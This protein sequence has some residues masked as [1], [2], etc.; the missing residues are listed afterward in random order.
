MFLTWAGISEFYGLLKIC[1]LSFHKYICSKDWWELWIVGRDHKKTKCPLQWGVTSLG[2]K[3]AIIEK[4][5]NP[6]FWL[7]KCGKNTGYRIISGAL[8]FFCQILTQE[9]CV[10]GCGVVCP[11]ANYR[12]L[13]AVFLTMQQKVVFAQMISSNSYSTP[14]FLTGLQ[15]PRIRPH[16]INVISFW[17]FY[18]ILI[19]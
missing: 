8:Y 15:M 12:I 10:Q 6:F 9:N 4:L 13:F 18:V 1:L 17:T 14:V 2:P 19:M 3:M 5:R 7:R 11:S 16:F